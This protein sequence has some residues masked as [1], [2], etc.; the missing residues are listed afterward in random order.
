MRADAV[1]VEGSPSPLLPLIVPD[2]RSE[3]GLPALTPTMSDAD[4]D[5]WLEAKSARAI[6]PLEALT[7]GLSLEERHAIIGSHDTI[8]RPHLDSFRRLV[9]AQSQF[10][11]VSDA[12]VEAQ[13]RAC[14]FRMVER[15]SLALAIRVHRLLGGG[16]GV[17]KDGVGGAARH[18]ARVSDA[19]HQPAG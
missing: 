11:A 15:L 6:V 14:A 3:A 13:G 10:D 4:L 5:V 12:V 8:I 17:A 2:L 7:P 9:R 16:T 1:S 19:V 18:L